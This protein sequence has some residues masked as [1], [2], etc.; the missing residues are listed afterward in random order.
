MARHDTDPD[1]ILN[2]NPFL[3]QHGF[4]AGTIFDL[5]EQQAE[6]LDRLAGW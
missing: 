3:R 5:T 6:A 1:P 2:K 4:Y